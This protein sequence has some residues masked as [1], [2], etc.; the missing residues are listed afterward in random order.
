M[1]SILPNTTV[2]DTGANI[3]TIPDTLEGITDT[4]PVHNTY[5]KGVTGTNKVQNKG[6][7]QHLEGLDTEDGII[8]PNSDMNCLSVP[9]RTK[10]GWFFWA[11]NDDAQLIKPNKTAYNFQLD[12]ES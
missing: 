4:K 7:Y 9:N 5:I 10:K 3:D 2:A 6:S 12:K 8:N 11:H 1:Y